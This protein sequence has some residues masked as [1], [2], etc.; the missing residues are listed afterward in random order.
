MA[1]G[2]CC[3]AVEVVAEQLT[4]RGGSSW[5]WL[6]DLILAGDAAL[7]GLADLF[8]GEATTTISLCLETGVALIDAGAS[9][10]LLFGEA[11]EDCEAIDIAAVELLPV[12][13]LICFS[14]RFLTEETKLGFGNSSL[15]ISFRYVHLMISL[16]LLDP[17]LD[18]V[19]FSWDIEE[20]V[21]NEWFV[22]ARDPGSSWS[23]WLHERRDL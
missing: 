5:L 16:S 19:A 17:G 18:A 1:S 20:Y 4:D 15:F 7:W 23:T 21:A 8:T 12:P 11:I 10:W 22:S 6:S 13:P 3:M 2:D 14:N 9:Y